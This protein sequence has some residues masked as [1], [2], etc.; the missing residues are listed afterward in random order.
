VSA[1]PFLRPQR[2]HT[3]GKIAANQGRPQADDS[4]LI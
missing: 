4:R 1:D 3:F 2:C